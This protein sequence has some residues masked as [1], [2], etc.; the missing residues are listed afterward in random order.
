MVYDILW[1]GCDFFIGNFMFCF[2]Y[3]GIIHF[4]F[5]NL[6]A[7]IEPSPVPTTT[8]PKVKLVTGKVNGKSKYRG[9]IC[10]RNH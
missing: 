2:I 5:D 4:L 3:D 6:G 7:Q 9:S 1:M 10:Q 8:E